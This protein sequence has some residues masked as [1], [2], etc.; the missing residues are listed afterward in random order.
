MRQRAGRTRKGNRWLRAALVA[1][2]QSAARTKRSY[3]GA[4]YRRIAARRGAKKAILAVAH[5]LLVIAYHVIARHEPYRELGA[6]YFDQ[7]KPAAT[8]NRL[9]RRLRQLGYDVTISTVPALAP[10]VEALAAA[11]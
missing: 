4:Q 2:A 3:L 10:P 9:L 8:A 7:Q 5:S 11:T 6:D 1:A